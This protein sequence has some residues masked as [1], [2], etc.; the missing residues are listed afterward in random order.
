ME[1][2][3]QYTK[4]EKFSNFVYYYKWW[5]LAGLFALILV[6]SFIRDLVTVVRPDYQVAVITAAPLS[7]AA[8]TQL[9]TALTALGEDL[10]GDGQVVVRLNSYSFGTE[11]TSY[12][13][14]IKLMADFT[15]FESHFILTDDPEGFQAAYQLL[16]NADG[17]AP[18]EDDYSAEG[19]VWPVADLLDLEDPVFGQLYLGRRCYAEPDKIDHLDAYN[20]LWDTLMKSVPSAS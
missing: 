9:E 5:M 16:A 11:T 10:N 1:E 6:G 12:A 2:K 20:A 15:A 7:Q 8:S 19:K 13:D 18:A 3:K 17:S 14:S 4:K